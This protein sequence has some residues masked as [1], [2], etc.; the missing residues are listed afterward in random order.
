MADPLRSG[1]G[2]KL[3]PLSPKSVPS[4]QGSVVGDTPRKRKKKKPPSTNETFEETPRGDSAR[5]HK[6][7]TR[8]DATIEGGVN[9]R[10]KK[11]VC[12]IVVVMN[13]AICLK[14]LLLKF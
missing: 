10:K 7:S 3:P 13:P 9:V 14:I 4:E 11:K 12:H 5:R 2:R 8:S 6:D 1:R